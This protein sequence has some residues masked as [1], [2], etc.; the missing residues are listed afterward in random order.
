MRFSWH[1]TCFTLVS[2][3]AYSSAMKME[4][5]C[6]SETSVGFQRATRRYVTEGRTLLYLCISSGCQ[7]ELIIS[8]KL[9]GLLCVPCEVGTNIEKLF[10]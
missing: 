8:V 1:A 9:I 5:T 6:S 2:F 4:A 3:L 7:N 10:I